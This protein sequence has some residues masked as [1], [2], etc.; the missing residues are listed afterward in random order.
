MIPRGPD[1]VYWMVWNHPIGGL[2]PLDSFDNG[3]Y[4]GAIGRYEDRT[5]QG[6][7]AGGE[8]PALAPDPAAFRAADQ[9]GPARLGGEAAGHPGAGAGTR[10]QP[11]DGGPG[12]R[13]AGGGG[14]GAGSR[15][16]GDLR[17][18]PRAR[19]RRDAPRGD[20]AARLDRLPLQGGPGDRGR[21]PPAAGL[22]PGAAARPGRH[23]VRG[24]H[25]GQR[26]LPDRGLPARAQPGDPRGGARAAAVLPGPR[27][28]P[29]AGVP[30][31]LS[32]ALRARG[33]PR[34]DPDR[35][36]LA[37][38]LRPGRAH[39]PRSGRLR[40]DRGAV[41]S[42][43][44]AGLPVVRGPAPAGAHG[45]RRARS[46]APRPAPRAAVAQ[47]ALLPAERPQPHRADDARR[48]AQ[49]AAR[50]GG[51]PPPAHH[52]GRLRRQPVLRAAAAGAA[53]GARPLG[54]R[55][56][57]RA[58]SRRSCSRACASAGSWPRRS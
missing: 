37:A 18:G 6:D 12:L 5:R 20:P 14:L 2:Q 27:L 26:A 4:Q 40:G 57:H 9:P 13:R 48:D 35:Q 30:V 38:G 1:R 44:H 17:R 47:A 32:P 39:A 36:R 53:E 54:P 51:A 25:A 28:P 19:A 11:D 50:G 55:R 23:L 42:A 29:A 43:R 22:Q 56:L 3:G 31:R 46:R 8:G 21:H 10:G 58:P 41:V 34:G 52:G 16:P 15:R 33:A 49:A 45:E 24:G 7:R